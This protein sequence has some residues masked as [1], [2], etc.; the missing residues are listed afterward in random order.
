MY[1]VCFET[2]VR[3]LVPRCLQ[4]TSKAET[5]KSDSG[6]QSELESSRHPHDAI[7]LPIIAGFG[8]KD[9]ELEAMSLISS[10]FAPHCIPRSPGDDAAGCARLRCKSRGTGL[11]TYWAHLASTEINS[12]ESQQM[13]FRSSEPIRPRGQRPE[14]G[15]IPGSSTE[16][17]LVRELSD[18]RTVSAI[19]SADPGL[20]PRRSTC[21]RSVGRSCR[22]K[23]GK[24]RRGCGYVWSLPGGP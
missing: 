16:E 2:Y 9:V 6:A 11:G 13:S 3:R 23:L 18:R 14:T 21:R 1:F 7:L 15:S 5:G 20:P 24:P 12:G 10:T 22:P 19:P 8:A 17:V 4:R